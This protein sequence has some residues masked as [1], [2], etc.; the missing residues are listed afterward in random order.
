MHYDE[1]YQGATLIQEIRRNYPAIIIVAYTASSL[2][3]ETVQRAKR[4]ADD[5]I[6]K[7]ADKETWTEQLDHMIQIATNPKAIWQRTRLGMVEQGINSKTLLELEDA[8]VG[9]IISGDAG[10]SK[11]KSVLKSRNVS[12]SI[13]NIAHALVASAIFKLIVSG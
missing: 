4:Y 1:K 3:S 8:Y 6:K 13:S 11:M 7:D 10:F 5:L 12:S 9:S 2:G